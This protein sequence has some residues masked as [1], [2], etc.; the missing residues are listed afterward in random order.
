MYV[1]LQLGLAPLDAHRAAQQRLQLA[2]G[3]GRE[4]ARREDLLEAL[5][6]GG[7]LPLHAVRQPELREQVRVL[8]QV[9]H[10]ERLRV[11]P[12]A[13]RRAGHGAREGAAARLDPL[14]KA[15]RHAHA[16]PRARELGRAH[17][18]VCAT[19]LGGGQPALVDGGERGGEGSVPRGDAARGAHR[20]Q[21]RVGERAAAQG[22]V[23]EVER[24]RQGHDEGIAARLGREPPQESEA[25]AHGEHV[26][27]RRA[28]RQRQRE[29]AAAVVDE[30]V[31]RAVAPAAASAAAGGGGG[32]R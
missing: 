31:V 11:A 27:A 13:E 8:L 16:Q 5:A 9:M 2:Q 24:E 29:E 26:R 17:L 12:G 30:A 4:R 1:P 6:E 28:R 32:V 20:G 23:E 22:E 25:L 18:R 15:H 19:R 3:E 21:R 10:A 7:G 14:V